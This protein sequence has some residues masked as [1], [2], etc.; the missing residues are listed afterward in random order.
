MRAKLTK[1]AEQPIS[2]PPGNTSFGTDLPAA[3][4]RSP[5]RHRR[6]ASPPRTWRD[7][8]M[9]L[10]ALELLE[11]RKRRVLVVEMDD[12][13]DRHQVL[14][15]SDRGTSRRW[16]RGR[17]ASRSCAAPARFWNLSGATC[18]ISFR[19]MPNFCGSRPASSA[20][21]AMSCLA[22]EPRAPSRDQRIFA[23]QLH[24][25]G[26]TVLRLAVAADAH[27][28]GRDAEHLAVVAVEHFGRGEAGIDLDA[29]R[30]RLGRRASASG[31]R[32]SRCNCRGCS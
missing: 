23:A 11:R 6:A 31:R 13:A 12:E 8:R 24:A 20:N 7:H 17:A 32:A 28:A 29:E 5:A 10:E 2:A 25:A 27:V 16:S 15:V 3:L 1:P 21:L 19:P 22:S 18:Q 4:G 30:L 26:E 14:A 9:R